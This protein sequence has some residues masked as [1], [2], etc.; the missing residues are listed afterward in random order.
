MPPFFLVFRKLGWMIRF[1]QNINSL[2]FYDFLL[3]MQIPNVQTWIFIPSVRILVY[4]I[5]AVDMLQNY[6]W[7]CCKRGKTISVE[8]LP[9][10]QFPDD[11]NMEKQWHYIDR[12]TKELRD[13]PVPMPLYL[14]GPTWTLL[15]MNP[16]LCD[17]KLMT[18]CLRALAQAFCNVV[19]WFSIVFFSVPYAHS[20]L[21]LKSLVTDLRNNCFEVP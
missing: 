11:V 18:N 9:I 13:K 6:Y 1:S 12:K 2:L 7:Y 3:H 5:Y 10:V 14:W 4:A 19:M 15:D 17:E 16:G 8:L 20:L 21:Y